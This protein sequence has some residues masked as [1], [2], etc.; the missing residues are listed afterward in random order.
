[1][2]LADLRPLLQRLL[3]VGDGKPH[4]EVKATDLAKG[5]LLEGGPPS[6][7]LGCRTRRK[8]RSVRLMWQLDLSALRQAA[9]H[10]VAEQ[11]A[12]YLRS[13]CVSRPLGGIDFGAQVR[14]RPHKEGAAIAVFCKPHFLPGDMCLTYEVKLGAEGLRSKRI[15]SLSLADR[16]VGSNSCLKIAYMAGGWD[17]Q[18]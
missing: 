16:I 7:A 15:T 6:W 2:L 14:C 4:Y 1:M 9:Q 10:C 12:V 17:E 8:V 3:L 18:A 13:P 11:V 5:G